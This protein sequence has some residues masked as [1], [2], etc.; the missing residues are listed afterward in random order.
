MNEIKMELFS[1][2]TIICKFIIPKGVTDEINTAYDNAIRNLPEYNDKIAGKIK[3]EFKVNDI[4]SDN[5][6]TIFQMCFRKYLGTIKKA[7]MA[8]FII[9]R[10]D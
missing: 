5:T 4:L 6:K 7:R 3:E 9:K 2:G 8:C 1:L 10:L